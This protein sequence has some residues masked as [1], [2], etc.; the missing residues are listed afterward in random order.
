VHLYYPKFDD[1]S[2]FLLIKQSHQFAQSDCKDTASPFFTIV[3][4]FFIS[5]CPEKIFFAVKNQKHCPDWLD[6]HKLSSAWGTVAFP[7]ISS[8]MCMVVHLHQVYE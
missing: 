3:P 5:F 7:H 6:F 8:R 1:F 2:V 4:G